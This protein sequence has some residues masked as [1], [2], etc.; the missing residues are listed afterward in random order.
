MNKIMLHESAHLH[1]SGEARHTD[2][3]PE[4]KGTLYTGIG[5]SIKNSIKA[6]LRV[7]VPVKLRPRLEAIFRRVYYFGFAYKCPFCHF[8][9][10]TFLPFGL[11]FPVLKEKKVVGGGCRANAQCP[12]CGS[13][14]RERLVYLYLLQKTDIFEKTQRVLHVSPEARLADVLRK[15]ASIDYLTADLYSNDV[16]V[17]MDI[18]NIHFPD[19]SFDSIICNHV[20]EHIIDDR[21]AMSELYRT[22]KAGRWSILQVPLSLSLEKTYEDFSI[23][24]ATGRERAFGRGDHVRIYAKDYKDRLEQAGFKV[25]VFKWITESENFGGR[26]NRF[27]LNEEECLFLVSKRL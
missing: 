22:L 12:V 3:L 6:F 25:D 13:L 8:H 16:M 26:T 21:K 27:G 14:D 7:L 5:A 2:D 15:Q 24:S 19:N 11:E 9:L 23:T 4:P 18:T 10:R 1:V 20:L 17:K